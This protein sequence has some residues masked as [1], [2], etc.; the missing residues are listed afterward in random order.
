[1]YTARTVVL[2]STMEPSSGAKSLRKVL[3]VRSENL[4][5]QQLYLKAELLGPVQAI[6]HWIEVYLGLQGVAAW[7]RSVAN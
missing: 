4:L 3:C 1:M 2:V 7:V 5:M 6:T